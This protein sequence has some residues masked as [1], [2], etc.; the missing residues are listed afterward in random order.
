MSPEEVPYPTA[1]FGH[2][3]GLATLFFIEFWERFSYY[4]MRALLILFMT[5]DAVK[6]GLGFPTATAGAIYG[7]YTASVYLMALPGGWIADRLIGQRRSVLVGGCIIA[8]GHF[9]MAVSSLP[10][11]YLGLVLIVLGTGLL[12]PNAST[13]VGELYPGESA[14]RDAGFS[15]FYMGI[16]LGATVAPLICGPLG[17]KVN[18]H[19]GFGAAGVGM[20]AGV[21]QYVLGGKYL[22]RAG[23]LPNAGDDAAGLRRSRIGLALAATAALGLAVL[24]ITGVV[25]ITATRL[26]TVVTLAIVILA[27][28]YFLFQM[29]L[30]G[31]DRREKRRMMAIFVLFIFSVIFWAGFEQAGSSLNLF[32]ERLTNRVIL[33]WEMPASVLQAI[34]PALVILI[35]PLL[36]WL[37][38]R[39]GRRNPSS[40]VKFSFGLIFMALGFATMVMAS[41]ASVGHAVAGAHLVARQVGMGWLVLTYLFNSV[42]ELCLS[43]VGLSTVTKLAPHRK[44]S[45]MMGIW[46]MALSLGNI[47]A[48]QIAGRFETFPLYQIFGLVALTA[49]GAGIVLLLLSR[50]IRSLMSGAE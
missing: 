15:I 21:V 18:W 14:R 33:G 38:V 43:P 37:W 42:G 29:F 30:G 1:F 16:N 36:A 11:F 20:L 27:V 48:G 2:P 23:L 40:P 47:I 19:F 35:A 45:Q 25:P 41:L 46:F 44:V 34:N 6:G 50:P 26:A 9:S 8:A 12:K 22:G 7:L 13:M 31:L 17:E 32:A 24:G 5:A 10:M 28:L 49:G 4:G 39:L 3:R